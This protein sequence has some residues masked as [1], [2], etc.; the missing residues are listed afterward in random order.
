MEDPL[1]D[2]EFFHIG[3]G[4]DVDRWFE[5]QNNSLMF[6]TA[7]ILLSITIYILLV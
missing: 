5:P 7:C 2:S 4:R 3:E 1:E 6:V